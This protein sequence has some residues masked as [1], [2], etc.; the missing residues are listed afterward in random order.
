MLRYTQYTLLTVSSI[1]KGNWVNDWT[2]SVMAGVVVHALYY[3]V[4]DTLN[5]IFAI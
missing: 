2:A 1:H 5:G 3:T 4:F